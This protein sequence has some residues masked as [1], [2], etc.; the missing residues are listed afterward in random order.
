[1]LAGLSQ[2]WILRMPPDFCASAEW[3]PA[4]HRMPAI[5]NA[6]KTRILLLPAEAHLA[7]AALDLRTIACAD[8]SHSHPPGV[9]GLLNGSQSQGPFRDYLSS[10]TSS[11]RL[12]L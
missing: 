1:M 2:C 8:G 7:D 9:V 4:M 10:Q 3:L 5:T 6:R 12:A 11:R